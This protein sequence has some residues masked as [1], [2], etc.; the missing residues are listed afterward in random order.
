MS[1]TESEKY[2]EYIGTKCKC[3]DVS[4]VR[5]HLSDGAAIDIIND[6]FKENDIKNLNEQPK[7]VQRE[8]VVTFR[9]KGLSIR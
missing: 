5:M 4:D 7:E 3:I 6:V 8:V 9:S 2:H 1:L